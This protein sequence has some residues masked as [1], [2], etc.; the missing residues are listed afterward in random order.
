MQEYSV[1]SSNVA[2][3]GYDPKTETLEVGFFDGSVYQYYNVPA[4]M[5]YQ[6]MKSGSKGRFP[7][8]LHQERI[9]VFSCWLGFVCIVQYLSSCTIVVGQDA[10]AARLG[11]QWH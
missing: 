9:S 10:I 3:V 2:S 4:N 8:Q 5:Y 7:T 11:A 6:F 1:A